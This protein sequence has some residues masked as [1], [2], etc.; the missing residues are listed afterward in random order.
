MASNEQE[1]HT[2]STGMP[3]GGRGETTFPPFDPVNFTPMLIWL[4]LS[5]GL[6]TF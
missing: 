3:G 2:A 4:S 5:F 6:L 1:G